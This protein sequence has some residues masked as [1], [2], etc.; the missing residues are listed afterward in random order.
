MVR[1]SVPEGGVDG[2]GLVVVVAVDVDEQ[3]RLL[4]GV[5]EHPRSPRRLHP[6]GVLVL[7]VVLK[8]VC[9]GQ[10]FAVCF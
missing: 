6:E 7:Q 10:V 1:A 4:V 5:G 8:V 9:V 3:A 2:A